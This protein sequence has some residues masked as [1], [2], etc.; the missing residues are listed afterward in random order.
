MK[1]SK[2]LRHLETKHSA[3]KDKPSEY[4][5]RK[6]HEQKGQKQLLRATTSTNTSA[7]RALYLVANRIAKVKK[8]FKE[9]ILPATK[10][11]Q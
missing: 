6:T 3:F 9:L 5:V 11:L 8:P 1:P 10:R 4:F 7:P 2:L